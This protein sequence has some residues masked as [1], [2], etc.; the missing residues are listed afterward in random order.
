MKLLIADDS[1]ANLKL[2]RA[3]LESEGHQVVAAANGVEAVAI[4]ERESVDA[5]ITDI[6][7]PS[8][9]GFRLCGEIRNST[10]SYRDVPVVLYTATYDSPSDRALAEA[11]GADAYILKP[12]LPA[13][14]IDAV[15][16]ALRSANTRSNRKA[17]EVNET[18]ILERYNAALVRK[19]EARNAQ[20]QES[21]ASL[22]AAHEQIAQLN[23]LL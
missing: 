9:D 22:Q 6:L 23:Q 16:E 7:M 5:V 20:V 4:L 17:P 14:L 2:L 11:V 13:V 18:Y 3:G 12:A 10:R 15:Q 19:L 8:M 1:P 21:L